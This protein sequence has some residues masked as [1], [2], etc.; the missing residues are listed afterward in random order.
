[1]KKKKVISLI[2]TI[3]ITLLILF[4][5]VIPIGLDMANRP[6]SGKSEE[7]LIVIE[8]NTSTLGIGKILEQNDVI[9]NRLSFLLK[10]KSNKEIILG[11]GMFHLNK[12]MSME[13]IIVKLTRPKIEI[14]T[15]TVTFPEG[16]TVEQMAQH[17]EDIHL[18]TKQEFMNA[19]QDNYEFE[20]LRHI[21]S[22]KY[23]HA[24][25]GFLFPDTYEFYEWSSAHDIIHKML[26]QFEKIYLS[27]NNNYKNMFEIITKASMIEKEAK[28]DSERAKI[29]GVI[30]NRIREN[31]LL[32]IDATVLYSA[33]K[34]LFNES[35]S[36]YI[37][38][39]QQNFNSPYNTYKYPGLPAGPICNPGEAAIKAALN[40]EIH[41]FLYYHT[42]TDKNDGSHLF[43]KTLDE[44]NATLN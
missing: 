2:C 28:L 29:A 8:E 16:Y 26:G 9:R 20:F 37:A 10:V 17:L 13:E 12:N 32:Q 3:L 4:A 5:F 25:Q 41:D 15:V 44:H 18:T 33:T 19:L 38:D 22:G 1:M 39:K 30:E 23:L 34:G 43:S 31:M 14:K 7:V 11:S 21:P 36:K 42:D 24:L 35:D 6:V 40:P 27:N